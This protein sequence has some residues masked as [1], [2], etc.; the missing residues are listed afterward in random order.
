MRYLMTT[1]CLLAFCLAGCDPAKPSPL[2]PKTVPH[3]PHLDEKLAKIEV[4]DF[5][6]TWCV[7]C[8]IAA[9]TIDVLI[10]Q[11]H[12]VRKIDAEQ[13]T[14]LAKKYKV[15]SYPTFI[16]LKRGKEVFRTQNAQELRRYMNKRLWHSDRQDD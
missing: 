10:A 15:H 7:P 8:R 14:E 6:S 1:L 5:Y 13:E 9:P 12:K 11:G 4:L 2:I 3:K 16:V